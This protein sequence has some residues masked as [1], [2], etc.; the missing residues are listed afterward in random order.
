MFRLRTGDRIDLDPGPVA[1]PRRI[2]AANLARARLAQVH[3]AHALYHIQAC[4]FCAS[5]SRGN[6]SA[7]SRQPD[8]F[9]VELPEESVTQL[10]SVGFEQMRA[11]ARLRARF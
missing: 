11:C 3:L 8:A 5:V 6:A 9:S 4:H 7:L 2:S 10:F 1:A